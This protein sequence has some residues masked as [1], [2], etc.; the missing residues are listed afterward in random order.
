MKN[1][2]QF[3]LYFLA[4]VFS[5]N[6]FSQSNSL[7]KSDDFEKLAEKITFN[8]NS[9]VPAYFE[10]KKG[11][12][13][14]IS[15]INNWIKTT[16]KLT[17]NLNIELLNTTKD[18]LGMIH[19]RYVQTFS[20]I[21]VNGTMLIVHTRNGKV[22][23]FNGIIFD[24]IN[25]AEIP[26]LSESIALNNALNYMHA[27]L[28][29][30]ESYEEETHLKQITNN[31]DTT[32]F[33]V[34]ELM[35]TPIKGVLKSKNLRL[36]Y[37]F[38]VYAITPLKRS[39]IFVDALTGEIVDDQNRIEFNNTPAT[40]ITQYNGN[41]PIMTYS[42][43]NVYALR[44]ANRGQG[45][46]IQT[47]NMHSG[48]IFGNATDFIDSNT[49]WNNVNT[50]RDEF[51]TD[52]H[53]AAEKSYDFYDSIFGRNSIDGS[54]ITLRIYA[55]YGNNYP[56][57]L[58]DGTNVCLG[59]NYDNAGSLPFTTIDMVG[60]EITHGLTHYCSALGAQ[61]SE[62]AAINEGFSD[63]M[64]IAIRQF[65]KPSANIN[66]LFG[67]QIG[68]VAYRRI[69][70][71]NLSLQASPDTYLGANWDSVF[72]EEHRNSSVFS[73]CFYLVTA[74]GTGT[75]DIGNTF[76]VTGIGL[77]KATRIWFRANEI[78]FTPTT[79]YYEARA[80]TIQ[81]AIDLYGQCSNEVHQV[82][83]AW[84]AV[85]IGPMSN[86]PTVGFGTNGLINFCTTPVSVQFNNLSSNATNY[87]WIFGDGTI[88]NDI[89][90]VHIY[91]TY[92]LFD[93]I[94][95]ADTNSVCSD[96][97][98]QAGII[99][100]DSNNPCI[101]TMGL[102]GTQ[103]SCSGTLYDI[104]GPTGDI[105]SQTDFT[106][107]IAPP[108]ALSI[109]LHFNSFNLP[110][111]GTNYGLYVY[112]GPSILSPLIGTYTGNT[113]PADITTSSGFVTIREI[114]VW[115]FNP[116]YGISWTCATPNAAPTVSF[117]TAFL[118]Q[119]NGTVKFTDHSTLLPN[120]WLWRFGDGTISTL[121]HPIHNYAEGTYTVTLIATNII[122]TDSLVQTG[123]L[124]ID[125][126]DPPIPLATTDTIFCG[127]SA[128][129]NA[130][131]NNFVEWY[132][133]PTAGNL[134][135]T[136]NVFV[137]QNLFNNTTYYAQQT[138][139]PPPV[140]MPPHDNAIGAG[141]FFSNSTN[142]YLIFD[143]HSPTL[144]VSVKVYAD[145]GYDRTIRLYDT[146]NTVL[147]STTVFIP[148]GESRVTLNFNIPAGT[149]FKLYVY[150]FADLYRNTEGAMYPYSI[151]GLITITGTNVTT[152]DNFYYY[153]Y[154]WEIKP[155]PCTSARVPVEVI[156]NPNTAN[157][158]SNIVG[159]T[160]SFINNT[161]GVNSQVWYFGDGDSSTLANPVHTYLLDGTYSVTLITNATNC[162][163]STTQVINILSTG[164]ASPADI[165]SN[166]EIIPNPATDNVEVK[167]EFSEKQHVNLE[168]IDAIGNIIFHKETNIDNTKLSVTLDLAHYNK[169]VYFVRLR[170]NKSNLV[171]KLIIN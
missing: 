85:G 107:T 147:A 23:S 92:G 105:G 83:N 19:Y 111:A 113:I 18:K 69:N 75:N 51:A 32:W 163:D 55:H 68:W 151:A 148:D 79:N 71:P 50:D 170:T 54:G 142:R 45:C 94:L 12:E 103:T 161:V 70:N 155:Q 65:A 21:A 130:P 66:W 40:A 64:A 127:D 166:F 154:D 157:F 77:D 141:G 110:G 159:N 84:Y 101:A 10:F 31:N 115:T 133:T 89:N 61:G 3:L 145:G 17:D 137:T 156:V 124:N 78:Y 80:Y 47:Y 46:S 116:G 1:N 58:W 136:G 59:D 5:A 88:S 34:G 8:N 57:A 108:N 126:I 100:I 73:H 36:S 7:V 152:S 143:C 97:I 112:D 123:L 93:V 117:Q 167:I 13:I 138:S 81:A 49:V 149:G 109:N 74:G 118:N 125:F 98:I 4:I 37:R 162:M 60:H 16:F 22:I 87:K 86:I 104:G 90:P 2:L 169:G 96:T 129:F 27:D 146:T 24:A 82:M 26:S 99:N 128:V 158:S 14:E 119:C 121:Q 139:N 168:I 43:G 102:S 95:I 122:G 20:H 9:K 120:S 56:N 150:N 134:M 153:F 41:R 52:A 114:N 11:N 132:D 63:C 15:N 48:V 25:T 91:N 165:I 53:W 30:W 135:D 39:Y 35:I 44:E 72:Q 62:A 164:I 33:P 38:D 76:S 29:R 28:Y 160:V 67:D 6:A 106:I 131:T 42:T 171:K 144:L 140:F